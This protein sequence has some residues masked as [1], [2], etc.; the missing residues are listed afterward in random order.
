MS[1]TQDVEDILECVAP[2]QFDASEA[3]GSFLGQDDV[4]YPVAALYG[5][6]QMIYYDFVDGWGCFDSGHI[7]PG[8]KLSSTQTPNGMELDRA[9]TGITRLL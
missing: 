9:L 2:L 6:T 7:T 5:S 8:V 4:V 3:T 1:G